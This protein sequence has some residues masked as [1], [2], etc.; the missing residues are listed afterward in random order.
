[1][2]Q[3]ALQRAEVEASRA[4]EKSR[5]TLGGQALIIAHRKKRHAA[6]MAERAKQAQQALHELHSS[7][8][9]N[10][11]ASGLVETHV[12][13]RPNETPR[14]IAAGLLG[15]SFEQLRDMNPWDSLLCLPCTCP[16]PP[17]AHKLS[18]CGW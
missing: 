2:E 9:G 14:Q 15:V 18:A 6:G 12:T 13:E 10:P 17:H 7:A 11:L 8:E 4:A 16:R 1:M 3:L 5:A